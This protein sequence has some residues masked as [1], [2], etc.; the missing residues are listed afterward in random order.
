MSSRH[1][2]IMFVTFRISPPDFGG[3]LTHCLERM[4]SLAE[5]GHKVIVLTRGIPRESIT[6][7]P[8][9]YRQL[10]C[11]IMGK[12]FGARVAYIFWASWL[13]LTT[14]FDVLHM[15]DMPA[16]RKPTA[17]LAAFWFGCLTRLKRRRAVAVASLV[18]SDSEPW[19]VR[20]KNGLYK[21]LHY[22]G[23]KTIVSVSPVLHDAINKWRKGKSF[24]LPYGVRDDL[25]TPLDEVEW[26]CSREHY[27]IPLD[28]IVFVTVGSAGIRKGYDLLA[29]AFSEL[30]AR[31]RNWYLCLVGPLSREQGC[32]TGR[33]ELDRILLPLKPV[34]PQ[35]RYL[36]RIDDRIELRKILGMSD[37]FVMP[38]RR[39]GMGIAPM[40]AMAM[41]IPA[42]VSNIPGVTDQACRHEESGLLIPVADP[43]A[44]RE[45]ME[46]LGGNPELR[47]T[48]GLSA[49]KRILQNFSWRAH[50]ET[51]D[52]LYRDLGNRCS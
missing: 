2:V 30:A 21:S 45:A 48:W 35:V 27:S 49:S 44:L 40:E 15:G 42:I 7:H 14:P 16:R 22:F 31:H 43:V 12:G 51:W 20:G 32:A 19:Q 6:E 10:S 5:L 52:R 37:V 13:L 41:G 29:T 34:D 3:E 47:R 9:A 4:R 50:I 38:T 1:L 8:A 36:G 23:V 18:E 46:L 24:C 11:P 33:E 25:F 26:R 39:E 17:A 28:G